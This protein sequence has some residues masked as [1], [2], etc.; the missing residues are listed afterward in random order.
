MSLFFLKQIMHFGIQT[1]RKKI[2]SY[3]NGGKITKIILNRVFF[4]F[5]VSGKNYTQRVLMLGLNNKLQ[6]CDSCLSVQIFNNILG[7]NSNILLFSI[8][9]LKRNSIHLKTYIKTKI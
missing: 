9:R 4:F 1:F 8:A 2:R 6:G 5:R 7:K 3:T